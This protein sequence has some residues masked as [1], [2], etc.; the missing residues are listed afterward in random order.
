MINNVADYRFV[1]GDIN[2]VIING[3]V[4]PVRAANNKRILRGE[5]LCFLAE[6]HEARTNL[7][8]LA[9]FKTAGRDY[10]ER[11]RDQ[12][13]SSTGQ[14]FPFTRTLSLTQLQHICNMHSTDSAKRPGAGS[15]RTLS[16]FFLKRMPQQIVGDL[17]QADLQAIKTEMD[18]II[19]DTPLAMPAANLNGRVLRQSEIEDMF[20]DNQLFR[21]YGCGNT[22]LLQNSGVGIGTR[23]QTTYIQVGTV[24][25]ADFADTN[26]YH[27]RANPSYNYAIEGSPADDFILAQFTDDGDVQKAELWCTLRFELERP[28]NTFA[29]KLWLGKLCDFTLNNGVWQAKQTSS[30]WQAQFRSMWQN[31]LNFTPITTASQ[32]DIYTVAQVTMYCPFAIVTPKNRFIW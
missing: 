14:I 24:S 25:P 31:L 15:T 9:Y 4:M 27:N 13:V 11:T 23:D 32:I 6:A 8:D 19:Q 10:T 3:D 7:W 5:D 17:T 26:I 21:L 12:Y 20:A 30:Q 16:P 2:R 18:A 1:Q 22:D 28:V 29:Y